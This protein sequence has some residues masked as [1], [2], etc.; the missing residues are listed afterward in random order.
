MSQGAAGRSE[1]EETWR[2]LRVA[3]GTAARPVH[4]L[5]IPPSLFPTVIE[6][7]PA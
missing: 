5:A 3:L 4:Y 6:G 2:A 7:S 1:D